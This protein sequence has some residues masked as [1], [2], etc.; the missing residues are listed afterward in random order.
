MERWQL[1]RRF[2]T[3]RWRLSFSYFIT[4]FAALLLL[5]TAFVGIPSTNALFHPP[6][7]H[8]AA[9]VLGLEGLAP[10]AAPYM[11]QTPVDLP[12]LSGWLHTPKEPVATYASGVGV[13]KES[14]FSVVPGDNAMLL[15]AD[16][17][18]RIIATLPPT[19]T[20]VG[21]LRGLE[22]LPQVST[23][24][25]A[26]RAETGSNPSN[27]AFSLPDGRVV[28]AVPVKDTAGIVH[29][30]LI[31]TADPAALQRAEAISGLQGLAYGVIPFSVIAGIFGVLIG[32]LMARGLTRRLRHLAAAA[33]AWSKGDFARSVADSSADEL[34]QLA[35]DLNHMA[36][37]LQMHLRDQQQLAV[38]EERNRLA[39]ELH[40]SVKQQVFAVKMLVGSAELEVGEDTEARRVLDEAERIAGNAQQELTALIHALRPVALTGKDLGPALGELCTDWSRRT[41]IATTIEI[42]DGLSLAPAAEGEV[43][44]TVQEA[45]ANIAR[46]SG[47]TEARVSASHDEGRLVLCVEDNGH[48]FQVAEAGRQ[49]IGLRSIRERIEGQGGTI[50]LLSSGEGT[51][52]KVTLPADQQ[53][54]FGRQVRSL[55]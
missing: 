28:A 50:L 54:S 9:M 5:E 18:A 11:S 22:R 21:N 2:G 33:G 44:R 1:S 32:L 6:H 46:H 24:I 40:D 43:F 14:T 27:L 17:S 47:A 26:A 31:V 15:V 4:T 13:D 10:Q 37:Q 3:L 19:A 35:R 49:G 25:A 51:R 39:R 29:G 7:Y 12:G 23:L 41:G 53:A 55:R 8:P 20:G 45:L 36:E 52:V 48:G 42:A 38:M 30:V 34:G 16:M